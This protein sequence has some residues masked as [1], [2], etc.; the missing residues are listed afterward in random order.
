M[1]SGLTVP[2][3]Y[4][5]LTSTGRERSRVLTCGMHAQTH[6]STP[7]CRILQQPL[8]QIIP[9]GSGGTPIYYFLTYRTKRPKGHYFIQKHEFSLLLVIKRMLIS[10]GYSCKLSKTRL[11]ENLR[12]VW[13]NQPKVCFSEHYFS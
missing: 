12:T 2:Q 3:V 10:C 11:Q 9:L 4:G 1:H 7:K 6:I 8:W 13:P 5:T